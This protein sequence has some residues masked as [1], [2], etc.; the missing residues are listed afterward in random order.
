VTKISEWITQWQQWFNQLSLNYQSGFAAVA[1]KH[2]EICD[3][4]DFQS[5][6]RIQ[7][8]QQYATT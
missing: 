3:R 7:E 2:K 8:E 6:C 1:P 5:L 4:C